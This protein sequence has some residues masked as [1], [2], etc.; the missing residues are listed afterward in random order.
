MLRERGLVRLTLE[1][2]LGA[3]K[4]L[5]RYLQ[6]QPEAPDAEDVGETLEMLR[7]LLARLN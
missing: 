3:A 2:Y 7:Q 6:L 5:G 4:D 1:Q